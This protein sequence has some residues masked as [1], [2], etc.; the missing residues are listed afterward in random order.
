MRRAVPLDLEVLQLQERVAHERCR[1]GRIPSPPTLE[2]KLLP[3]GHRTLLSAEPGHVASRDGR[4][5]AVGSTSSDRVGASRLPQGL[6][7]G[8]LWR[9]SRDGAL[10]QHPKQARDRARECRSALPLPDIAA[11]P[12]PSA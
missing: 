5:V 3:P 10:A 12:A 6:L 9:D 11:V 7:A 1:Y 2:S 8:E 4:L